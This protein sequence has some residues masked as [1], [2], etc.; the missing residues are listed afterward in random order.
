MFGHKRFEAVVSL[1]PSDMTPQIVLQPKIQFRAK[2]LKLLDIKNKIRVNL[3][4]PLQYL[5]K[6]DE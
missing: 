4:I 2:L 3:I 1:D 6:K 5:N